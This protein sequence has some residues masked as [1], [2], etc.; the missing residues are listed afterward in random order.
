MSGSW[1]RSITASVMD[2]MNID[3]SSNP[4]ILFIRSD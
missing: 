4:V 3:G 2:G 1:P